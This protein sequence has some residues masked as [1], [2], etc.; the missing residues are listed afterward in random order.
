MNGFLNILEHEA[1]KNVGI[2]FDGVIHKNSKGYYDGTIYDEPV[3]GTKEALA[4]L[5]S[6]YNLI[7]YTCKAKPR[8]PLINGKTGTELIWEW[9][10]KYELSVY[11][12]EITYEKPTVLFYIDDKAVRFTNWKNTLEEIKEMI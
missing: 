7:I 6:K 2:D 5:S 11:I 1:S 9:L 12:S 3:E 4:L 10:D 8:R